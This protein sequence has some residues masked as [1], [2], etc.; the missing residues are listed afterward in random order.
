MHSKVHP[1]A[2]P[3]IFLLLGAL[4]AGCGGGP[5]RPP[6]A[7]PTDGPAPVDLRFGD[8]YEIVLSEVPALPAE[9]PALVG[10]SLVLN[11]AYTGGC[12]DHT[13]IV[14]HTTA[15]DTTHLW[16]V[17]DDAGDACEAYLHADLRL[18]VPAGALK[19]PV[20]VLETPQGG[21]PFML[22]WGDG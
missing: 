14:R 20:V 17:H 22:R 8:P 7:P 6:G 21:P 16:I 18:S 3:A 5:Q 19:A 1:C 10:D 2:L 11:V 12:R 9:P 4:F 13:F 15:R